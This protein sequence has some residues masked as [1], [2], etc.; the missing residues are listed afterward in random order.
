LIHPHPNPLP[1]RVRE[2]KKESRERGRKKE[3]MER[4]NT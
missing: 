3:S 4:E 1:G 2:N